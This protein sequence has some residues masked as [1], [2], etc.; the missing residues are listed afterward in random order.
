M[1]EATDRLLTTIRGFAEPLLADMGM[2]LVE[3]QF[4]R[5]GHGWVLRLFIDKEGGVAIDDCVAVSREISAYLEVEDLIDH[6][7]HLEVSSP[8]LER[9]LKKRDDFIRFAGKLARIKLRE[10]AAGQRV[11][12]GTLQGMEGDSVVLTLDGETVRV[13]M[14]NISKARLTL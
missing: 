4:R 12:V 8:G 6:A 13:D 9:P 5:E 10:A 11:L 7:Y 2:E 14:E 3:I 1:E